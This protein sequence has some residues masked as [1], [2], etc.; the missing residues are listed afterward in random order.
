MIILSLLRE[1][2]SA[3]WG[4][5]LRSFLTVLGM[6]MGVT[7]VITIVS[8]VEGLQS[9][10]ENTLNTM[11]T[12]TF[13]VTRFGI[14]L[15]WADYLERLKRKKLVRGLVDPIEAGCPDCEA[16]G[17]EGYAWAH[18]KYGTKTMN[19]VDIE[20]HTP[21]ILAMR[22]FDIL[23]GRYISD[24][25]D[26]RRRN[27][28]V[29]GYEV[30]E[31]FFENEE[32]IGKEIRVRGHAFTVIGVTEKLDGPLVRGLDEMI[33]I[34]LSTLHKLFPR[35]GNPVNLI[36]KAVSAER[37]QA[38]MDQ[39]RVVL[40]AARRVP[41]DA[42][43]DFSI[44]TPEGLLSFVN[45][46]TRGF[47]IVMVSLPLLSMVVGGIVIMNIMMI[48]VTER[49]REIG[50][51]KAIGAR[52]RNICTQFLF[53]SLILSLIGGGLGVGLGMYLGDA[54]LTSWMEI[55][56]SPSKLGIML[57]L[58][59]STGVGLFFGIYPAMK[60]ARLDPIKALSYE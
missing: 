42:D 57:G 11:G 18:M 24:E 54:I 8:T 15:S 30:Y 4:N 37:R 33:L 36:V 48:S 12:N 41:F 52:Q 34:P 3:L 35:P 22:D 31:K 1:A 20:G 32:P 40:R 6:M 16:V 2:G 14:G 53:E 55:D 13:T 28:C 46:L 17:A 29:L 39:V 9:D 38:A 56:V 58:I 47:R 23:H 43:D 25:D 10:M 5:K 27:V 19:W 44:W 59:I 45:D 60:A 50:V 26:R 49:T 7:S 51:R 21:N